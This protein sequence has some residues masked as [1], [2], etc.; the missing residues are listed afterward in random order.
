[1]SSICMAPDMLLC[2]QLAKLDRYFDKLHPCFPILDEKTFHE[3]WQKDSNRLSSALVCDIYASAL[4]FWNTSERLKQH[5][6]PDLVVS[7]RAHLD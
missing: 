5:P 4:H 3:V 2:W 6:R 1:M 7:R